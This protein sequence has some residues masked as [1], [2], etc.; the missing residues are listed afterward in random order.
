MSGPAVKATPDKT[1]EEYFMQHENFVPLV[2][3]GLS[4]NSGS[5]SSSTPRPQDS[6]STSSSPATERCDDGAPGHL[7]DSPK[8]LPKKRDDNRTSANRLRDLPEWLEEIRDNL[9][10]AEVPASAYIS[11]TLRSG[12]SYE[13]GIKEAQYLYSLLKRPKLRYL[14]ATKKMTRLLA[15][16]ALAKLHLEQKKFGDLITADL[17]VLNG[18][19]HSGSSQQQ[20]MVQ[21]V[22]CPLVVNGV[23]LVLSRFWW[24]RAYLEPVV[25]MAYGKNGAACW[26]AGAV[27]I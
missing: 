7:R 22:A 26:L 11:H 21:M 17:K 18:S 9:D 27:C 13:S 5:S 25:S 24:C 20:S 6:S 19:C 4:S 16:D 10:D 12:T 15:E 1:G 23:D 14:L 2:V 8:K 3:P